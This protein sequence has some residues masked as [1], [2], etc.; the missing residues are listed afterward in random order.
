[1]LLSIGLACI[2]VLG[3]GSAAVFARL[4]MESVRPMPGTLISLVS[5]TLL[6]GGLAAAFNGAE[7]VA[8]PAMA[9][10]WFLGNGILTYMGGRTQQY[11]AISLIGAS[12]VTPI[13]GGAAL[14]AAIYAIG[15]TRLGGGGL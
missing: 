14:F 8:L 4:G 10:P 6:A 3:F 9:I 1:M 11:I 12:R 5:S 15:L 7:I 2:A 13:V